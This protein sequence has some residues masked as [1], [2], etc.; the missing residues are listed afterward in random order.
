M[1]NDE[2]ELDD[3]LEGNSDLSNQYHSSGMIE[4]SDCLSDKIFSTAKEA[5]A[6]P[7]Q[8]TK[9][10]F[11]KSAW[12]R[13][14]AIAA[15]ITL[16]VSLV[17]TKQQETGQPLISEPATGLELYNSTVL[18]EDVVM[19]KP[20]LADGDATIPKKVEIKQSSDDGMDVPAAVSA[21]RAESYA[22]TKKD[23]ATIKPVKKAIS[24]EK[25][26]SVEVEKRVF[27]K[28]QLLQ[29]APMEAEFD[30]VIE[31]TQ[32]RQRSQQ[33]IELL[34]IKSSLKDGNAEKAKNLYKQ[35]IENYPDYSNK[36]IEEILGEEM[37]GL[38]K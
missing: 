7:K 18:T 5:T 27:A 32:D 35:F 11:H 17:V 1:V 24:K 23:E 22:N 20:I 10:M 34:K 4:P 21:T 2:K 31:F 29:S 9:V 30:T 26:R 12:V 16:S 37:F 19:P 8:K 3:Y 25:A 36:A 28:E 15:I 33:E 38:I 14:V 13:P 6:I